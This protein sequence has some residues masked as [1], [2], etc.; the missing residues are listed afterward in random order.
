MCECRCVLSP[1]E[2]SEMDAGNQLRSLVRA[3]VWHFPGP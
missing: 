1:E 3:E 2:G